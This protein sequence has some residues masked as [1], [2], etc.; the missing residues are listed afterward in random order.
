MEAQTKII[1]DYNRAVTVRTLS[2]YAASFGF[3]LVSGALVIFAPEHRTVAANIVA[4]A[5][6]LMAAGLAGFT[7]LKANA[8][9]LSLD[10]Y[11]TNPLGEN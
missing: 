10:A 9:G 7:R 3:A 8:P 2:A 11:G 5:F 4:G 1:A 6:L